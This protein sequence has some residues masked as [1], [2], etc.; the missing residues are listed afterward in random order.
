MLRIKDAESCRSIVIGCRV[1]I[2]KNSVTNV[3][4]WKSEHIFVGRSLKSNYFWL[5]DLAAKFNFVYVD[6]F[7]YL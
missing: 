4:R 5:G 3:S 2:L 6:A 1:L 7:F